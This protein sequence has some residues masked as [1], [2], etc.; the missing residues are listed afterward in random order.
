VLGTHAPDV[1]GLAVLAVVG[2]F[3]IVL[4]QRA[5]SVADGVLADVI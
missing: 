1:A 4:A 5:F 2:L 3:G